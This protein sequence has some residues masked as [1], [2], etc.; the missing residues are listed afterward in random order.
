LVQRSQ[1]YYHVGYRYGAFITLFLAT[2][3]IIVISNKFFVEVSL[4]HIV[5]KIGLIMLAAV[6]TYFTRLI[7]KAEVLYIKSLLSKYIFRR[8]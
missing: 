6:L 4:L 1:V 2:A 5:A 8:N 7:G 3:V